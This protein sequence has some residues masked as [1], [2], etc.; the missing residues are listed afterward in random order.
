MAGII[1]GSVSEHL[2]RVIM[3]KMILPRYNA[4]TAIPEPIEK[5]LGS[6]YK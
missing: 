6:L 2:S 5:V 4:A 1:P 3:S